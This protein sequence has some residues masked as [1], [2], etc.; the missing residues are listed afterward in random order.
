MGD[1]CAR[2]TAALRDL[3]VRH[4][5]HVPIGHVPELERIPAAA[6]QDI[7]VLVVGSLNERRMAPID[8]LRRLG[9]NAQAHFGVYG[10]ARDALY[11]RAK[12]VVNTH[13]Y[14]TKIF[15]IVRVSYL[16]ANGV[17]VISEHCADTEEAD[18]YADAVVFTD[19]DDIVTT[20]LHYL[21][22]PEQRAARAEAGRA[23]MRARPAIDYLAPAV[24]GLPGMPS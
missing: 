3:G 10:S 23:V 16:L 22:E 15:E 19:Y 17:F 7:D 2:N 21:A 9:L 13:F 5:R 6:E 24:T 18:R 11:A 12:I 4:A 8:E 1:Y 20:C 14:D